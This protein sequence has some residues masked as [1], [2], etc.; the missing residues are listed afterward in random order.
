MDSDYIKGLQAADQAVLRMG[1]AQLDR[2]N[3]DMICGWLHVA[4]CGLIYKA[5]E[6]GNEHDRNG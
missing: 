6:E 3:A 2:P 4:I 5:R 1:A